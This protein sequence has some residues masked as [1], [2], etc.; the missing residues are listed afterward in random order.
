TC[1]SVQSVTLSEG[2]ITIGT[3]AFED[4]SALVSINIPAGVTTIDTAAFEGCAFTSINLP[5]SVTTLGAEAFL[6][7]E[8]LQSVTLSEGLITIGQMTFV[9]TGLTSI[10]IPASVT[11]IG[12]Y[13]FYAYASSAL[14]SVTFKGTACQNNIGEDA[15]YNVGNPD[16][17][18]LT[19]PNSWTGTKPDED[20]NWYGGKFELSEDP[21]ALP[22][23]FGDDVKVN[24]SLL[25]GQLIIRKGNKTYNTLGQEVK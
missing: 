10:T 17:A 11:E 23:L 3:G 1:E 19:L 13:A 20:G 21:T 7:C 15:F 22:T 14:T 12:M 5:A 16:P 24:K 6:G 25:N 2:L 18:L 4:C 9:N 8:S